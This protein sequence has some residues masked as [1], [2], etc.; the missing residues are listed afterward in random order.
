MASCT[1]LGCSLAGTCEAFGLE[2]GQAES[3]LA[4]ECIRNAHWEGTQAWTE[5]K[6]TVLN[7]QQFHH[8]WSFTYKARDGSNAKVD[9][10]AW[11]ESLRGLLTDVPPDDFYWNVKL[12]VPDDG[13]EIFDELIEVP[14]RV[15]PVARV[16]A[17]AVLRHGGRA[18]RVGDATEVV[19][20]SEYINARVDR[21]SPDTDHGIG[22]STTTSGAKSARTGP[23]EQACSS[24]F[25]PAV[26]MPEADDRA[27][28]VKVLELLVQQLGVVEQSAYE[29]DDALLRGQM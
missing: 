16:P 9:L 3:E 26:E 22:A 25:R 27:Q 28:L 15:S 20:P 6:W 12:H 10:E 7:K 4:A 18:F 5:G 14:Y 13:F 17:G 29:A 11:E 19:L 23:A 1:A 2:V 24:E 8:D 21:G